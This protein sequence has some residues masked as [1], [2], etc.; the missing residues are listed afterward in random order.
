[1]DVVLIKGD[2]I[3]KEICDSVIRVSDALNCDIN[4]IECEAGSEYYEKSGKL[5]EDTLLEKIE[6]CGL[7]LKGPTATPIGTGF[8]SINVY[9]RQHFNTYANVRPLKSL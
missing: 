6:G 8:R 5:M 4:W 7:A 9:L 2:G 3:G 1:M